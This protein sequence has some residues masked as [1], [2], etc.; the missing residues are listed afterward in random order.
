[1]QAT[2][3]NFSSRSKVTAI[4]E[5]NLGPFPALAGCTD[6][7]ATS[8]APPLD[9]TGGSISSVRFG[10]PQNLLDCCLSTANFDPAV[11]SQ[12]AHSAGHGHLFHNMRRGSLAG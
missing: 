2:R 1:M 5:R 9:S 10:D 4:V 3:R 12:A 11:L 6:H 7:L 8:G